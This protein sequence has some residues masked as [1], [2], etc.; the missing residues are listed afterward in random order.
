MA[1]K[2][3][4]EIDYSDQKLLLGKTVIVGLKSGTSLTGEVRYLDETTLV[5]V[6]EPTSALDIETRISHNIINAERID[7][8]QFKTDR[9]K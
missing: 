2:T 8:I 7:F 6:T 1:K 5:L 4:I 9:Q 3:D